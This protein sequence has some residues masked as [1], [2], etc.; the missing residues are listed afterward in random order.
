MLQRASLPIDRL[1]RAFSDRTRR[2]I[3]HLLM[4]AATR[5]RK[6]SCC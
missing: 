6:K 3:L 4:R 1:F 5:A 2:R